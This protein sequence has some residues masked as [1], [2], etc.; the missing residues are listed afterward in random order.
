LLFLQKKL[1]YLI[2]E[3]NFVCRSQFQI[4]NI[5]GWKNDIKN[6]RI[7]CKIILQNSKLIQGVFGKKK[8]KKKQNKGFGEPK[9]WTTK[10]KQT[11]PLCF[12]YILL[13]QSK[14]KDALIIRKGRR[15]M[16]YLL[17]S[18]PRYFLFFLDFCIKNIFYIKLILESKIKL[19]RRF[20][21]SQG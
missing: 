20:I 19:C 14:L 4:L 3:K 6:P 7:N 2:P 10:L 5:K 16:A 21:F 1:I 11:F 13:L 12:S 8:K 15:F 18:P 17:V 9:P